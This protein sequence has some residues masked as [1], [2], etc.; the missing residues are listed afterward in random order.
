MI[1]D[2]KFASVSQSENITIGPR[3]NKTN[4]PKPCFLGNKFSMIRNS[5]AGELTKSLNPC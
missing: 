5:I 1:C 4:Y 3:K 2:I